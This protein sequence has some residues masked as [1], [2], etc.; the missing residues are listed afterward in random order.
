MPSTSR[1]MASGARA[2][3]WAD[4]A[5]M[6]NSLACGAALAIQGKPEAAQHASMSIDSPARAAKT[7]RVNSSSGPMA[8]PCPFCPPA[9]E[10]IVASNAFALCIRDGY[11]VSPGHTLVIPRRHAASFWDLDAAERT[12]MLEL[13]DRARAALVAEFAPDGFNIGINDGA[14]A[15][16]TVLHVH[17][18][19]IPRYR[20]DLPD[21]RGGVRWVIPGKADYWSRG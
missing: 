16:Q 6:G 5:F 20:G 1:R 4:G 11:P 15:G 19:L 12:A 10:R 3:G 13:L 7:F 17:L 2:K 18:H 8:S 9:P 21:P 14:A